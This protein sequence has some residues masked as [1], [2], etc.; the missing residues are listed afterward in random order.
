MGLISSIASKFRKAKRRKPD[1]A[2]LRGLLQKIHARYDAAQNTDEYKNYWANADSYDADSAHSIDVR[3]SLIHRSRYEIGNNG[4]A[5]GIVQT[6]ATDLVGCGPTLRMQT[7]SDGFN[8][9]VENQW[10]Q[11][12]NAIQWRRKLWC[13]AHA[14]LQDGEAF[15]VLRLNRRVKHPIPLDV[16]LYE[17]EQVQTPYVEFDDDGHIDGIKFDEFGN[18]LWYD[19]MLQH[20]GA[21]STYSG[22]FESER[23]P[24]NR[25]LHWFKMRRPGQHRGIPELAST[26]QVGASSRRMREA[27]VSA[28]ESAARLG[29]VLLHTGFTP[30]EVEELLPMSTTETVR[31]MMTALPAGWSAD[32]MKAEHPNATYQDFLR[33]QISE[34]AR[35]KNMP[36]NKAA[37]DSSSY[38]FASGRL[39]HITYYDCL[40]SERYDCNEQ[41][42]D[43]LF[44]VWFDAAVFR[45]GWLGGNPEQVGLSARA[46]VWDWANHKVADE[47]SQALANAQKLQTGQVLLPQLYSAMGLDFMDETERAA[48]QFGL[49]PEELRARLLDVSLPTKAQPTAELEQSID[50]DEREAE[51]RRVAAL[52]PQNRLNGHLN[53]AANGN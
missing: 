6:Y 52:L 4:Y 11:W 51:Q 17:A 48:P 2:E 42:C 21:V 50:E 31:G 22:F 10:Y 12:T 49:T 18:P 3:H 45:Y 14:K 8:R 9:M 19:L 33:S 47:K 41:V 25:M 43:P 37:C 26:L 28:V 27:T 13:M 7:G 15:G 38:N 5:D 39:D 34:L 46:H 20:P 16:V 32:Q 23:I 36:Y 29:A 24:A 44:E 53:G 35:P 1:I 40:D 30:S